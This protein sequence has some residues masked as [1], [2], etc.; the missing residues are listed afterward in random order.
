M[1]SETI[2][3][4]TK[5][6]ARTNILA[7]FT[8]MDKKMFLEDLNK[9]SK[10]YWDQY[11]YGKIGGVVNNLKEMTL[12]DFEREFEANN[13]T[14]EQITKLFRK[15]ISLKYGEHKE[16]AKIKPLTKKDLVR[17]NV[18]EDFNG[19]KYL[20]L[21]RVIKEKTPD[22]KFNGCVSIV[23]E[24]LGFLWYGGYIN[25]E[26]IFNCDVLKGIKRLKCETEKAYV[27]ASDYKGVE[28]DWSLRYE[29]TLKL[30]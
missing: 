14:S 21:G 8:L 26:N 19:I 15:E 17:G 27:L 30:I 10:G 11:R 9:N 24:G 20:Y 5:S 28:Y 1:K 2:F 3:I 25:D 29:V 16:L 18:Y 23:E 4:K 12:Q 13:F 6:G 7:N 22:R